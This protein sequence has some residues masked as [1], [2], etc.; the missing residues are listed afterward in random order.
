MLSGAKHPPVLRG[1][2]AAIGATATLFSS[3]QSNLPAWQPAVHLDW[4]G[5]DRQGRI[6][7]STSP[8]PFRV[9]RV[10]RGRFL[11]GAESLARW[12]GVDA[13][14]GTGEVEGR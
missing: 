5:Y 1:P 2:F 11:G 8:S 13:Q 4:R 10:F 12:R 3:Q 9:F 14:V 7:I 6:H